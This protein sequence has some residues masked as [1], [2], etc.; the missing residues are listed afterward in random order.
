MTMSEKIAVNHWG[1]HPDNDND[2]CY[3]GDEFDTIADA[4]RFYMENPTD[5]G[6]EYIEIDLPDETLKMYNIER[7]RKNPKFIPH[8]EDD[9]DDWRREIAMQ[10]GMGRGVEAYNEAMGYELWDSEEYRSDED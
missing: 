3:S 2:D 9:N 4:I 8:K 6:V 5:M 10:E 1:S 7:V